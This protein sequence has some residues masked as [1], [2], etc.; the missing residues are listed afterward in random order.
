VTVG[1]PAEDGIPIDPA[2]L[3]KES[4]SKENVDENFVP[5]FSGSLH[6]TSPTSIAPHGHAHIVEDPRAVS[7][8]NSETQRLL[9]KRRLS[10]ETNCDKPHKRCR[11]A[12]TA[13][14]HQYT[15]Y[16]CF[17]AAPLHERLGFLAWLLK[18]GLSESLSAASVELPSTRVKTVD[19]C[20]EPARS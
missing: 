19:P 9:S 7:K 3:G 5:D 8:A 16:S 6:P 10:D 12:L 1:E 15:L 17:S 20:I 18:M 14:D 4:V 11:S 2:I 13:K